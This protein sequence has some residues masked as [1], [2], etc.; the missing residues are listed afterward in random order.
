VRIYKPGMLAHTYNSSYSGGRDQE[1]TIS[2]PICSTNK[3]GHGVMCL[4]SQLH[5]RCEK[6]DHG[7]GWPG[8]KHKTLSENNLNQKKKKK[9]K[10]EGE[11]TTRHM[12]QVVKYLPSKH[13]VLSSS[14]TI[15]K[16]RERGREGEREKWQSKTTLPSC[17]ACPHDGPTALALGLFSSLKAGVCRARQA[18]AGQSPWDPTD[19]MEYTPCCNFTLR[20]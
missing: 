12:V 3:A 17:L 1:K 2:R 14:T 15:R 4:S 19:L 16:G 9:K 10:S 5:R 7:P 18:P 13:A 20:K 11:N 8:Q 6:V